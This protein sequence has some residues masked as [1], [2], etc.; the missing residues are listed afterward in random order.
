MVCFSSSQTVGIE[1]LS[2][3]CSIQ[4]YFSQTDRLV[5][6]L[7]DPSQVDVLGHGLYR[8]SMRPIKFMMLQLQPVSDI[9]VVVDKDRVLIQSDTCELLGQPALN[10]RFSL[11][12]RGILTPQQQSDEGVLLY[13]EA[14]LQVDVD[15]PAAFRLTPRTI[16][17][18]TGNGILNSILMTIKQR[19][20]RQLVADYENWAA[21]SQ[22]VIAAGIRR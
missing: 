20:L 6:A 21:Q 14:H 3:A 18:A 15:L 1:L 4:K 19:L 11:S 12:L 17:E 13:G 22:A 7:I 9:Q 16:L 2:A 8:L 10:K 5:Y